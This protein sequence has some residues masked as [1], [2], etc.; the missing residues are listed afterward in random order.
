MI[1]VI[2][3]IR[4]YIKDTDFRFTVYKDKI[5]IV[6]YKKIISL[7]DEKILFLGENQKITIRGKNLTLNKLLDDEILIVGKILKIEVLY[8]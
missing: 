5:D 4:D 1:L 7:E 8:E 3:S 2:D 6:N